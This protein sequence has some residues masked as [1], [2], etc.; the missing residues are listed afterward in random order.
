[1]IGF[2]TIT[3]TSL[4]TKLVLDKF[5]STIWH[6]RFFG[7]GDFEIYCQ[8]TTENVQN[9]TVGSYVI[10]SDVEENGTVGVIRRVEL[11]NDPQSGVMLAASGYYAKC[12]LGQRLLYKINSSNT[13][14]TVAFT[15]NVETAARS[16]VEMS[17]I[18]PEDARRT[19][20]NVYLGSSKGYS[21]VLAESRQSIFENLLDWL[22]SMLSEYNMTC[23]LEILEETLF[24]ELDFVVKKGT[25]RSASV[26]IS[27][28]LD[29]II[30]S[31]YEKSSE[32][33]KT[34]ALVGGAGEGSTR[35][36]QIVGAS[37]SGFARKEV[38]VNAS[39]VR[40]IGLKIGELE[41]LFPGGMVEPPP[42]DESQFYVVDGKIVALYSNNAWDILDEYYLPLLNAPGTDA[43][44]K[45]KATT[46][47]KGEIDVTS[48]TYKLGK[49]YFLGDYVTVYDDRLNVTV[50]AQVTE[51]TEVV[52]DNGTLITA[53][54]E[55]K[56]LPS[57]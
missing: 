52:D 9:I 16:A 7:V 41:A 48:G 29:N 26:I 4:F 31:T 24:G 27:G 18:Q 39:N 19:I 37:A 49:D 23:E 46:E 6:S 51:T 2:L 53:V 22:T 40:Q 35:L 15:G 34:T 45:A 12:L 20:P 30:N 33:E 17:I 43:L 1:M 11:I 57:S 42:P 50:T 21:D 44:Q 36:F 13:L 10:R 38:Y 25:D 14:E 3:N 28:R 56:A 54:F 32:L 5:Q 47:Y 8:A 55:T